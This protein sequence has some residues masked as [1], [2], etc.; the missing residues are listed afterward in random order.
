M[1][2][3]LGMVEEQRPL[4]QEE[5]DRVHHRVDVA[6]HV[7]LGDEVEDVEHVVERRPRGEGQERRAD[8]DPVR[9]KERD[10]A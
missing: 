1:G 4:G 7:V 2:L 10:R 6:D 3:E 8:L 9:A 5:A